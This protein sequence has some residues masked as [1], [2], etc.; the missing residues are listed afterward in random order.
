MNVYIYLDGLLCEDCGKVIQEQIRHE[1]HRYPT[2]YPQGPYT[3]GGGE[4][5]FPR[6]CARG[7]NCLNAFH[8]SDGT[9]IGVWL[10]NEL[11][12][13][14]VEYVKEAVKEGGYIANLW[15]EWYIDLDYIL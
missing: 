11:T 15:L 2:F 6:H 1:N 12:E 8:C 14:G 3:D 4:S 5:D 7:E 10:E 13:K 9:K